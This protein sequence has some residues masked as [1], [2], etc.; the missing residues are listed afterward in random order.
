MICRSRRLSAGWRADDR[1]AGRREDRNEDRVA[2][3]M[4]FL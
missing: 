2:A 3:D 1:D 4:L